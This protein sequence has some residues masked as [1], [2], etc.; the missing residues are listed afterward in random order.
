MVNLDVR[1]FVSYH[2]IGSVERAKVVHLAVQEP[3]KTG[4]EV[5]MSALFSTGQVMCSSFFVATQTQAGRLSLHP[6]P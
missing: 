3:H 5:L 1:L 6:V 2:R 4:H